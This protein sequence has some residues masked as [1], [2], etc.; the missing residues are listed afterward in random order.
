MRRRKEFAAEVVRMAKIMKQDK[1]TMD[2]IKDDRARECTSICCTTLVAAQEFITGESL[3]NE[4]AISKWFLDNGRSSSADIEKDVF[5]LRWFTDCVSLIT[6]GADPHAKNFLQVRRGGISADGS[7]NILKGSQADV[8]YSGKGQLLIL[9]APA[10][11]DG[12]YQREQSRQRKSVPIDIRNIRH[13]LRKEP[14]WIPPPQVK[15]N[16]SHRFTVEGFRPQS[17]WVISYDASRELR[18]IVSPL[19]E[20]LLYEH[21]LELDDAGTVRQRDEQEPLRI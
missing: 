21:D 13:E 7:I 19:Y 5:R 17:W 12:A 1:R 10:E 18:D 3:E 9:I 20:R 14:G 16:G 8:L 11:L 2:A 4:G 6:G 15:G